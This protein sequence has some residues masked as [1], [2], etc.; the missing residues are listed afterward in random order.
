MTG[1]RGSR[2]ARYRTQPGAPRRKPPSD[3]L[4][5][6]LGADEFCAVITGAPPDVVQERADRIGALVMLEDRAP[7]QAGLWVTVSVGAASA[8]GPGAV[9]NLYPL[10][11]DALYAANAAR[12]GLLRIAQ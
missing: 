7:V 6:R 3:H 8:T 5:L 10:A 11:D 9:E 2:R 1:S 4:A 12:A